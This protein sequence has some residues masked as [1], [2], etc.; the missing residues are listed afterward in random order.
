MP[1]TIGR[2][3]AHRASQRPIGFADVLIF[4]SSVTPL[5]QLIKWLCL[6]G[7]RC[8]SPLLG[9]R[10]F[11]A[12]RTTHPSLPPTTSIDNG[13]NFPETEKA[14]S[15]SP[16]VG[17]GHPSSKPCQRFLWHSTRSSRVRRCQR[18][19][20][21]DQSTFYATLSW[22]ISEPQLLRIRWPTMRIM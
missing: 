21:Y 11:L 1:V 19:P 7:V 15:H 10:P 22:W 8:D 5:S 20:G 17:C 2:H 16:S 6:H 12:S 18:N 9:F 14:R 3:S 13:F 4:K